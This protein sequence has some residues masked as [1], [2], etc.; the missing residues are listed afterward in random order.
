MLSPKIPNQPARPGASGEKGRVPIGTESRPQAVSGQTPDRPDAATDV[1]FCDPEQA[2]RN[3]QNAAARL[4]P[5]LAAALPGLLAD[6]PDP[7][8]G[9]LL[10]DRLVA[11]SDEIVRLL[12]RHN[13]LAHY[14]VVVFGH[15]RFLGET[16]LQNADLLQ[17]FLR[18]KNLDRSFSREEFHESLARFR[19]RSFDSDVALILARFKRREYVRIVLRDVLKIAPLSE[20][21]AE[22]S[23]LSD[24]LIEQALREADSI[25]QRRYGTPQ[26]LDALGRLVD[27]PF[28]ILALGKLG[29]NELNYSSDVDLM[30]LYGDGEE[31]PKAAISNREYFIRLAQHTTEILSRV[32]R[33]GP[34]FRIDL[35]LRPQGGEG[36]LAIRLSQALSYYA[37][38]AHDWERQALIKVRHSAGDAVLAREFIRGVQPHI[39][40]A[41]VNFAAIKT[42]LVAREKMHKRRRAGS[43]LQQAD[44]TID[45]KIDRGGIRDIEF[46]VQCLQRVYGGGEPWL[47]SGGTLFSLQ[48][49]HDKGHISGKEFH[50]LTSAYEFLRHLEHRLQ[51]REGQQTH[52]LPASAADC[53]VLQRA[54][55]GYFPGEH[56]SGEPA[57]G[58][59]SMV[60]RRMSAVAEIYRRIIFQQQTRGRQQA[61]DADF[62]LVSS[63]EPA[64]PDQTGQQLLQR[65]ST[66]AP[67]LHEVASRHDLSPTI[68][69]NLHRFLSSAFTSSQRYASVL[70]YQ[71][72]ASRALRLFEA[73]EYLSEIL[74]RHPEEIAT[75]AEAEQPRPRPGRARLFEAPAVGKTLGMLPAA[76]DPVFSYLGTS[77][78]PYGE[79]LALLRQH[80]RHRAFTVGARDILELR[81]VYESFG[82]ITAAADDVISAAFS[83]AGAPDGLA[84]LAVGRLGSAEFELLSDADVLFVCA[85]EADRVALTKC[86]ERMM[87]ALAAYTREGMVFPVDARLRPRGGEG[88]LIITPSHLAAYFEH[89][90]QPWE[91]LTY[92]KLRFLAGS[93]SQGERALQSVQILFDRFAGEV[94][95]ARSVRD[96]RSKLEGSEAPENNFKFSPGAIYDIDFIT[97]FLLIKHGVPDKQGSL[98]DR[99][100]R[101]AA[102]G[103]LTNSDAA[104]LDHAAELLRTVEHF[105]RLVAGRAVKWLPPTEHG[106]Q[107]TQKLTGQ[108]LGREFPD[109]LESELLKAFG[110][111]RTVFNRIFNRSFEDDGVHP[112]AEA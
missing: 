90:A 82:D 28:A 7:D 74:I 30:Y 18:E 71:E 39:Y 56:R 58:L 5:A 45:V 60:T 104:A 3:L 11:G 13:F 22:I 84:V 10:F 68:R 110:Q 59:A 76:R 1:L 75:L 50:Q 94:G 97:G 40:I 101:C 36:E 17:S 102:A 14:A 66:D 92:A 44:E 9:L 16:L 96:M 46:L 106:R 32:T 37:E 108:V 52:R 93:Q 19:A 99:L 83:I 20:T 107:V 2:R 112:S 29:G 70:R 31:P 95:F 69:R 111:V 38:T 41:E 72:Q 49:L 64:A 26:H 98:R 91:A 53:R 4:S 87:H 77:A 73:S 103:V 12:D 23:A 33:E 81:G 89:E 25:L 6:I 78:S 15:S 48:K 57:S 51:L 54:M 85:E 42:A 34:V 21:T 79:K 65:L 43:P 47:R 80:F 62:K 55:E 61:P 8:G 86:A 88:E 27:T 100:W 24:V 109:G 105:S 63:L 67:A 35:R